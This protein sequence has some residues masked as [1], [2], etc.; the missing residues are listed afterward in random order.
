MVGKTVR[1]QC[2]SYKKMANLLRVRNLIIIKEPDN[3][4]I[5]RQGRTLGYVKRL[6]HAIAAAL[7]VIGLSFIAPSAHAASDTITRFDVHAVVDK[8]GVFTVTQTID[9]AFAYSGHGIYAWYITRQGY[10]DT[11]DRRINYTNFKV[12][13]PTGA[14][15]WME[16]STGDKHISLRIGD[17]DR[18]V[19]GTQTYVITYTASGIV[20]PHV[21]QSGMDEIYWNVVGTAWEVPIE[22]ISI[23]IESPSDVQQTICYTGSDYKAPCTNHTAEG[24][25]ASFHQDSLNPGQGFAVV[26]GWPVGSFP[27]ATLDLVPSSQNPFDLASGGA[28]AAGGAGVLSVIAGFLLTRINKRGRDEQFANVTPGMVPVTGDKVEIKYEEVKDA[29]V[30]FQPPQGIPPR[31]VSAVVREGTSDDDITATIID[32][33]VR[34]YLHFEQGEGSDFTIRRTSLEPHGL[35]AVEQRIYDGLFSLGPVVTRATM[36]SQ[37]FYSTYQSFQSLTSKEFNAQGWYKS[38]PRAVVS[39][40]RIGGLL[41]ALMGGAGAVFVGGQF[42][43]NGLLGVGWMAIPFILLGLGMM[44]LAKRMPVRTAVG[45]AVAIQSFGFK[46]YLET[47]EAKQ[48]KWEEGQD[49]FSQYLPY[50]I[51]FGCADRWAKIFEELVAMGA[52]VPHPI[53]YTGYGRMPIWMSINNSVGSI[54]STF[55]ESLREHVAAQA[56]ATGGSSGGSGFSGGGFGGGVGGGGGGSW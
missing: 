5:V 9:M 25:V 54:E 19:T 27:G 36:S 49:I 13:S 1:V 20:N 15:T 7:I 12:S 51:G 35:T 18:S 29:A 53:W 37:G 16:T 41:I 47:A 4:K 39:A 14:P 40:W 34:G 32:L 38:S 11:Q 43:R 8:D 44:A 46:K 24:R 50:A 30:Q 42:A 23:T 26:G 52:P 33:A 45:S 28:K 17:P 6:L 56:Q 2:R 55:G 22:N 21:I 31:L 10:D 48:I 3:H